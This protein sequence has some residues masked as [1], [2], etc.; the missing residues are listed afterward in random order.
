[1]IGDD[2]IEMAEIVKE[3]RKELLQYEL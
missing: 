2:I 3:L 1:M